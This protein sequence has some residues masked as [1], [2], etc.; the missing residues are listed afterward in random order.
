MKVS[1]IQSS[2]IPESAT[3]KIWTFI[4]QKFGED[5]GRKA[6]VV[7]AIYGLKSLGADFRNHLA[8]C[9]YHLGF[10]P[11]SSDLDHWMKPMARPECGFD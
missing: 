11:C 7:W 6:I 1:D 8:D 5:A 2:Y 10:F 4:G 9:M 3:E